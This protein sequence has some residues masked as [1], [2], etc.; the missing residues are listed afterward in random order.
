[1]REE[2]AAAPFRFLTDEE[3]KAL[4]NNKAKANYLVNAQQHLEER[5]GVIREQ[6]KELAD[7][8]R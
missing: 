8:L 4:D 7:R 5:Q 2:K 1:M 6:M 3:F